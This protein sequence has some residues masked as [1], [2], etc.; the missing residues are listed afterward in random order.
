MADPRSEYLDRFYDAVDL[1]ASGRI[2]AI[3]EDRRLLQN[4]SADCYPSIS[5]FLSSDDERVRAETVSL[6]A[7]VRERA[8]AEKIDDM[9]RH[10][11]QKVRDECLG[12]KKNIEEEDSRIP[13]L[14]DEIRHTRGEDYFRACKALEKIARK[15]DVDDVREVYGQTD[16]EM[17]EAAKRILEAILVRNPALRRKRDLILSMPVYPDE[18]AFERFLDRSMDYID[19]RY[20]ENVAPVKSVSITLYNNVARALNKIRVRLYNEADNLKFYGADKADRHAE[21]SELLVWALGDFTKKEVRRTEDVRSAVC[22]GC[23]GMMVMFNGRWTCPD[24]GSER[25]TDLFR[26]N[27]Y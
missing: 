17:Q 14:I 19:V 12:Y 9:Y 4:Y 8:A 16:G 6:L 3:S 27:T 7:E 21:L 26:V 20:R 13:F 24:C 15:E 11:T 18:D 25:S 22:T 10:D 1:V 5:A 2:G 23:G